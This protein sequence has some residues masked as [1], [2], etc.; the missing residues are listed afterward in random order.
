MALPVLLYQRTGSA[1][2]TG[3]LTTVEALPYLLLGLP[4]GALA[5][6]WDRRRTMIV[7]SLLSAVVMATVPF[8]SAVGVLTTGHVFLVGLTI[9]TLFVF[10]D[11]AGFGAL[12]EIVGRQNVGA[13]TGIMVSVSTVIGLLGPATAGVL[14]ATFGA[15]EVLAV[16]A[17]AYL[18]SA[19]LLSRIHW[20][21]S[22]PLAESAGSLLSR[23]RHDV[24]EGLVFLWRHPVV[25]TLTLLGIGV[26]I[27]GGAVL[28]LM[29]VVGVEQLGLADDDSRLGL[30]YAA[31]AFGSLV[32]STLLGRIQKRFRTGTI[33]LA[34]FAV[35]W[36]AL[37]A[38]SQTS[39]LAVGLLVLALW[40]GAST[41]A[42]V[43]GIVVRQAVTP[44]RLQGR[45]NTTA[46]MIA[47]GGAPLGAGGA[48]LLAEATDTRTALLVASG[49]VAAAF[50]LGF[51][52]GLARMD[53][54]AS[55]TAHAE[56]LEKTQLEAGRPAQSHP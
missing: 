49:G 10:S 43:N 54:L 52:S 45:V 23:T 56:E 22:P 41:L 2:L 35:N 51:V 28:G 33:S 37:V 21:H 27:S 20:E 7:V 48:G 1:A 32:V 6:R 8:A 26:S 46:R 44:S 12:P 14:A 40:Q 18:L 13:A 9:S 4:V 31:T 15:A 55:L 25:R 29:V 50:V 36:I 16:D 42:I 38:W 34:A 53:S 17:V 5:D 47:W 24:T 11:A 19:V 3:L 39:M 30:L